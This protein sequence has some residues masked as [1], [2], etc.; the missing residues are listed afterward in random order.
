SYYDRDAGVRQRAIDL[1]KKWVDI[2][3]ALGS[4]SIRNHIAGS[5]SSK[6]DVDR[7]AESLGQVVN[8]AASKKVIV[9]LENDD[10]V[11]EDAFFVVKLVEKVNSPYLHALPDFCNSMLSGNAK[12]D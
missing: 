11:S 10:L 9:N 12:F 7:A 4:P 5:Q 6:P 8:Y 1:G 3:V 2:A